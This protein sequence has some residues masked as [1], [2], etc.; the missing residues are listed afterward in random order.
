MSA[1]ANG[2]TLPATPASAA[3]HLRAEA[4]VVRGRME[5]AE[6]DVAAIRANLDQAN[7]RLMATASTANDRLAAISDELS[8]VA[9]LTAVAECARCGFVGRIEWLPDGTARVIHEYRVGHT[10]CVL[11]LGADLPVSDST[12]A[13]SLLR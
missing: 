8:H 4:A 5:A 3:D 7:A 10:M 2:H 6:R 12:R 13:L 9:V 11:Q 1:T